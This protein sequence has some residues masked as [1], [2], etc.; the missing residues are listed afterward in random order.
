[1]GNGIPL[2]D[3]AHVH[4]LPFKTYTFVMRYINALSAKLLS[5]QLAEFNRF[6]YV[7]EL[8]F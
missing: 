1:M 8:I 4:S 5:L 3:G 2:I 6:W 7:P